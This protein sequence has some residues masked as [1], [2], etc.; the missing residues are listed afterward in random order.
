MDDHGLGV[1]KCIG[2][3]HGTPRT[4]SSGAFHILSTLPRSLDL[5]ASP[6]DSLSGQRR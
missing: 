3:R 6:F 1:V 5:G 4:S 2:G